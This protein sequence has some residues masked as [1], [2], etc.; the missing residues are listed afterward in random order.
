MLTPVPHVTL[1]D[2]ALASGES[3]RAATILERVL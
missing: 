1:M 2:H 3:R